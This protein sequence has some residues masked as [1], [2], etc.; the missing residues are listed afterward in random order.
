MMRLTAPVA[1]L[2]LR[3]A[4]LAALL[5]ALLA[6]QLLAQPHSR[7]VIVLLDRSASMPRAATLA[8]WHALRSAN[9]R[10]TL[11]TLEFAGRPEWL[12]R[13]TPAAAPSASLV[14]GETHIA[15]AVW[16]ALARIEARHDSA[17]ALLSDGYSRG[18]DVP[19]ALRAAKAAGVPVCWR[20]LGR[21][22]PPVLVTSVEAPPTAFQGRP[23]TLQVNLQA[24]ERRR[25]AL[26]AEGAGASSRRALLALDP[27]RVSI[28]LTYTPPRAGPLVVAVAVTDPSSGRLLT[29]RAHS[30]IDVRGLS[31]TLYIADDPGPLATSL[32]RGG[33]PVERVAP[34][35][36]PTREES[37]SRYQVVVLEDVAIRDAPQAFWTALAHQV[38]S[39]GLGLVVLGGPHAFARGG[40]RHSAL[41]ALLPVASE[42]GAADR[43]QAVAFV[44]DKS[45]SMGRNSA[46]VDRL[47]TAREAV[48]VAA[49]DLSPRDEL[50]LVAFDVAPHLL[51]P[52]APYRTAR[53][54]LEAPWPVRAAGG[55]RIGPALIFAA[56]RLALAH[57]RRRTLVLMTDGYA[58]D[59]SGPALSRLLAHDSIQL[60]VIAIG[61]HANVS[62]LAR[63]SAATGAQVLRVA[64]VAE[65]P[66]FARA[67]LEAR[68]GRVHLGPTPV[69]E[70]LSTPFPTQAIW[71]PVTGYAVT[72]ARRTAQLYLVS[73]RGDP[74][75]ASILAGNGR[76]VA[77]PAGLGEWARDWARSPGWPR[78]AGGLIEWA[79]RRADDP[80]LGVAA[81][82]GPG[83]I[84]VQAELADS[85]GWGDL[86]HIALWLTRPD[87][88][89]ET[90]AAPAVAPGRYRQSLLAAQ[91]GLYTLT[92]AAGAAR[93]T[94][95]VLHEERQESRD[96]GISPA[97]RADV[98]RGWLEW[99]TP[100]ALRSGPAP[101]PD[102]GPAR[103][104]LAGAALACVLAAFAIDFR[105]RWGAGIGR[106]RGRYRLFLQRARQ[107]ARARWRGGG[108]VR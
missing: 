55:T 43:T 93:T 22:P 98:T 47:S 90:L 71:A 83:A 41:E 28:P 39:H 59:Q 34:A 12:G 56:E 11:E 70:R 15:R 60:V 32:E 26:I 3:L 67:A 58:A 48:I 64:E 97:L 103:R 57:S 5:L 87:G 79:S 107:R 37:L 30:V 21:P 92:A 105:T 69:I 31:R 13:R 40:Y 66:R 8:A 63:L 16:S 94:R 91:P 14:L 82:D 72:R 108:N 86:G 85:G 6:P 51:V 74:L 106:L 84:T 18:D 54:A 100:R 7:Q 95:Y 88:A 96:F 2:M 81:A 17:I 80:R 29:A 25:V 27:G 36:A 76:V 75:L 23:L 4:A 10:L 68:R 52:L 65:L 53:A 77:L 1:A 9:P 45:G 49:R 19:A 42:P 61:A 102:P 24:S 104:E 50:M 73:G 101:P 62:G 33:W 44:V 99:C 35:F 38:Q 46:G 20:P 89:T 78:L